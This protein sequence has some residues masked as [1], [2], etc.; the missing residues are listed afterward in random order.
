[1]STLCERLANFIFRIEVEHFESDEH[2]FKKSMAI[3]GVFKFKKAWFA[4]HIL[5][6]MYCFMCIIVWRQNA[7]CYKARK[8]IEFGLLIPF[9]PI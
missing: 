2:R 9:I 1:M 8:V 4:N 3:S 5:F 7:Y 6:A